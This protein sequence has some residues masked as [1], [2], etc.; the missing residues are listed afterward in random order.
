MTKKPIPPDLETIKARGA[1]IQELCE[2]MDAH[3]LVLDEIIAMLDEQKRAS[4]LYQARLKRAK[5]LLN[6][7]ESN[8]NETNK[9]S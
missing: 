5:R 6:L 9:E 2:R 4:P 8:G 7:P 1:K 3:I